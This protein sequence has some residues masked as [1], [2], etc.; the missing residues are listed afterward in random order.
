MQIHS[1][2]SCCGLVTL[3]VGYNLLYILSILYGMVPGLLEFVMFYSQLQHSWAGSLLFVTGCT[4][5]N[6]R[7]DIM[8]AEFEKTNK[9][10]EKAQIYKQKT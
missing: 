7:K 2:D 3:H 9:Q 4:Q 8:M 6:T 10:R 1:Q 5:Y